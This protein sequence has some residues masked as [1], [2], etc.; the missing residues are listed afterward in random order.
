MSMS[1]GD[2]FTIPRKLSTNGGETAAKVVNMK[3]SAKTK[4][5]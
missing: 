1:P 5:D 4:P 3:P 2:P